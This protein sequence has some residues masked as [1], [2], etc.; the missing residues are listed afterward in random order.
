MLMQATRHIKYGF[1]RSNYAESSSV[2]TVEISC[3]IGVKIRCV[4]P[5]RVWHR[6]HMKVGRMDAYGNA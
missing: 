1:Q 6:T 5:L 2:V 4:D 3:V